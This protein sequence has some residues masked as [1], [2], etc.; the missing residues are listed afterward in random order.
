MNMNKCIIFVHL[1]NNYSGSPK[2][3]RQVI[4]F[5]VRENFF[6]RLI[7]N[8]TE[9][10]LS[11][12]DGVDYEYV[13]Y[14]WSENKIHTFIRFFIAQFQ[15]FLKM[16]RLRGNNEVVYINTITPIGALYGSK[17]K[18]LK[19]VCHVHENYIDKNIVN[20]MCEYSF[21]SVSPKAIFVSDY[22]KSRY[23]EHKNKSVVAYNFLE[24]DFIK[25][26][27]LNNEKSNS[28][29]NNL[30]LMVCSYRKFKGIY[31]FAELS[32]L[33]P[34]YQ[35][36]LVL[37][38]TLENV[39]KFKQSV[40]CPSNLSVYSSQTN[41]HPFYIR[42]K[43]VLNLSQPSTWIET[44]GL[45]I[46]EAMQYGIPAIVPN[47]GGPTELIITNYNGF[48]VDTT[49]IYEIS[50]KINYLL[51]NDEKYSE[52]SKNCL[53]KAADFNEAAQIKIIKNIVIE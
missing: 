6:V 28:E 20:R 52:F 32:K 2:V 22:L 50:D 35:F 16:I 44:F 17:F 41:L 9:G 24:Y 8:R 37:S 34:Q 15:L 30:V 11:N 26:S 45:T 25:Q 36:E 48:Q 33:L 21:K 14:G 23:T 42:A 27:I 38:T 1:F 3:L 7:T 39:E 5:F 47:V 53:I 19:T 13:D 43:V 51:C 12:I 49:N 4:E 46:L 31:E 18:K 10:F 29:K 40:N